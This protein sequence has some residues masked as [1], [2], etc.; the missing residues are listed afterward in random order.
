MFA[1]CVST[2]SVPCG[3]LLFVIEEDTFGAGGFASL[4]FWSF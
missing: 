4:A 3:F 2:A 1:V